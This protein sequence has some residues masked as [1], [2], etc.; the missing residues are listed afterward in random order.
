MKQVY[1]YFGFSF[2]RL[3]QVKRK[4]FPEFIHL[5]KKKI[6]HLQVVR[7][8]KSYFY[9]CEEI[10]FSIFFAYLYQN[11][12]CRRGQQRKKKKKKEKSAIFIYLFF[13]TRHMCQL[14]K[15]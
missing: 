4:S 2:F 5:L 15:L 3:L 7:K 13:F 11:L 6:K 10:I 8:T 12:I 14:M 1:Y 9:F